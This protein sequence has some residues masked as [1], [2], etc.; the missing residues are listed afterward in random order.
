MRREKMVLG[1][2]SNSIRSDGSQ[3]EVVSWDDEE[4]LAETTEWHRKIW[5]LG[6][7]IPTFIALLKTGEYVIGDAHSDRCGAVF[8]RECFYNFI[9]E[10]ISDL[11]EEIKLLNGIKE[12]CE[13]K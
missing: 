9:M 1:L 4:D 3:D 6:W 11:T 13:V 2:D 5:H 8:S 10:E 12:K 7:N